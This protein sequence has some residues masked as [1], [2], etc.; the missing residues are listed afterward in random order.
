MSV[1][2]KLAAAALGLLVWLSAAEAQTLV[3]ANNPEKI[4]EIARGF[5]S[6]ELDVDLDQS[7][8]ITGRMGGFRYR[9]YFY[10]CEDGKDCTAIQFWTYVKAPENPLEAVNDWNRQYRFGRAYLDNVGD[11]TIEMDVNLW[12]GVTP[13]NLDDTFDWWRSVLEKANEAFAGPPAEPAM[14]APVPR[15]RT[16]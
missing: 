14:P 9:I 5:G 12:G 16:L 13:K 11:I 6:A 2:S 10:G 8:L 4:L 1:F 3:E 7:P 15:E